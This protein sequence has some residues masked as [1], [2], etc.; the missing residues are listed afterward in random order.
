MRRKDIIKSL[1]DNRL[2]IGVD[3]RVLMMYNEYIK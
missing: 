2:R 1:D 3:K